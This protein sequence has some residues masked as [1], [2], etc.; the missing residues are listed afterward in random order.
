[1]DQQSLRFTRGRVRRDEGGRHGLRV[2]A[3]HPG[4][5]QQH[6][7]RDVRAQST[8]NH[9]ILDLF[10]KVAEQVETSLN[11]RRCARE[12]RGHGADRKAVVVD[13]LPDQPG[14][15]QR[16]RAAL[17]QPDLD[18]NER[19]HTRPGQD[20]CADQV[21][22]KPF[23]R[24]HPDVPIHD[25]ELLP[26]ACHD[27]D[28]VLLTIP[29]QRS[30]NLALVG[31]NAKAQILVRLRQ[32]AELEVYGRHGHADSS[33]RRIPTAAAAS[34]PALGERFAMNRWKRSEAR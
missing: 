34:A 32:E 9:Q 14:F 12:P 19:V 2:S 27:E 16:N 24:S 1:M 17:G 18:M 20:L 5:R 3:I 11:P 13:Q 21:A 26:R 29:L 15:F 7:L 22:S 10:G 4:H 6:T 25:R 28:R 23:E 33:S 30:E 8:A 31:R